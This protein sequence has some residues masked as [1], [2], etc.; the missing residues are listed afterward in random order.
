VRLAII[1]YC[2]RFETFLFVASYDSQGYGGGGGFRP[3]LHSHPLK[4]I[5]CQLEREHLL[6][7]SL[8]RNFTVK[9]CVLVVTTYYVRISD[10]PVVSVFVS[11][12][13]ET[14]SNCRRCLAV[15]VRVYS[16][17]QPLSGTPQYEPIV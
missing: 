15:E 3:R 14:R 5:L 13:T 10:A 8:L 11:P 1:F 16:N 7:Y 12:E 2:L 17:N 6:A 4:L 9:E